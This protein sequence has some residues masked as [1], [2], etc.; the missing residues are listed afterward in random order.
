MVFSISSLGVVSLNMNSI[1]DRETT[2]SYEIYIVAVDM[3]TPPLTSST[4]L[5]ISIEDVNDNMP[6]FIQLPYSASLAEDVS[7]GTPVLTVSA[8]DIDSGANMEVSYRVF[9]NSEGKFEVDLVSG[10]I[11][12]TSSLDREQTDFYN[13]VIVAF[14]SGSPFMSSTA[15][16]SIAILDVNDNIPIFSQSLYTGD[17]DENDSGSDVLT[18]EASDLDLNLNSVLIFQYQDPIEGSGLPFTIDNN[19]GQISVSG[20]LDR[21]SIDIYSFQVVVHDSAVS[22]QLTAT[23]DVIISINDLND[24]APFF[25]GVDSLRTSL[26]ETTRITTIILSPIATDPDLGDGGDIIYSLS[27]SSTIFSVVE[28]SGEIQLIQSLDIDSNGPNGFSEYVFDLVATDKGN[29][30]LSGS[31]SITITVLNEND[32]VPIFDSSF[33]TISIP[34]DTVVDTVII[35]LTAT[36]NDVSGTIK[37][38]IVGGNLDLLFSIDE[39]TG[40]VSNILPLLSLA[41]DI[42]ELTVRAYESGDNTK[43]SLTSLHIEISDTNDNAPSFC[44]T[45]DYQ[46]SVDENS[47]VSTQVGQICGTDRDTGNNGKFTFI[48]SNGNEN[49]AFDIEQISGSSTAYIIVKND[50]LDRESDDEYMLVLLITDNGIPQLQSSPI[51]A[52]ISILD[53]NDETPVLLNLPTSIFI[54]EDT[55]GGVIIYQV[56]GSDSDTSINADIF[57]E[58]IDGNSGNFFRIESETGQISV[59][60]SLDFNIQNS[61]TLTIQVSDKGTIALSAQSTITITILDVNNHAPEFMPPYSQSISEDL[62]TSSFVIS[63]LA[64]DLDATTNA[65][66]FYSISSGVNAIHFAIDS[67][68][69]DIALNTTLDRETQSSYNIEVT[70][71]DMGIPI[72]CNSV[73]V[74]IQILDTNDHAPMFDQPV[75]SFTVLE[76]SSADF[77]IGKVIASDLDDGVNGDIQY[78]VVVANPLFRIDSDSGDIFVQGELDRESTDFYQLMIL[79]EDDG[80]PAQSTFATVNVTILDVNDNSPIIDISQFSSQINEDAAIGLLVF[81]VDATDLDEGTNSKITLSIL[82]GDFDDFFI[83]PDSG[84]VHVNA[85]LSAERITS[86]ELLIQASDSSN[87]P[88]TDI[89][90]LIITIIDVNEFPPIFEQEIYFVDLVENSSPGTVITTVSATDADVQGTVNSKISFF[91]PSPFSSDFA[92]DPVTGLVT[93]KSIF[94]REVSSTQL[95]VVMASNSDSTPTLQGSAQVQITILDDNDEIPYF[96]NLPSNIQISE[97]SSIGFIVLVLE[98]ND[99]DDPNHGNGRVFFSSASENSA[100]FDRSFFINSNG[101]IEVNGIL[102]REIQK[103]YS[104]DVVVQ[105]EGSPSLSSVASIIINLLDENDTPP[106][107]TNSIYLISY[108]E[109]LDS[110]S[111]N[112]LSRLLLTLNFTDGDSD[113]SNQESTYRLAADSPFSIPDFSVT[114]GGELFVNIGLD[115][116]IRDSYTLFLEVINLVRFLL[117]HFVI[118]DI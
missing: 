3:G 90:T 81:D 43:S 117:L 110:S 100:E 42:F 27:P 33:Y 87:P 4:T 44:Q 72:M 70:A 9:S 99:A 58:I 35:T 94:D 53:V 69:G 57:F 56:N 30:P 88:L 84:K 59:I 48:I 109:D 20:P 111:Q 11:Q 108:S 74:I 104:A 101:D 65:E 46:F 25:P 18:L 51:L 80:V 103:V 7:I 66:L 118:T 63:V 60:D 21:E 28:T 47:I 68:N 54:Q 96:I 113:T 14:D 34:E 52:I 2:P 91:I 1:L 55:F 26:Q 38:D 115:R 23:S 105:D 62:T 32:N 16:V 12:T 92:I 29:P 24:V 39:D 45:A 107:F 40:E 76:D 6:V 36:D 5:S 17:V 22:N 95:L 13:L 79:A 10:L 114:E 89:E 112:G 97:L 77:K 67:T 102:D 73:G 82:G 31:I 93:S 86:Y 61:F 15:T 85:S 50:V 106:L 41:S 116:E 71:C 37:Y 64:T 19:S 83:I 98:A 75:Y 49:D 8:D 78:F